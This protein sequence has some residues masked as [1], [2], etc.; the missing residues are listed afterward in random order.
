MDPPTSLWPWVHAMASRCVQLLRCTVQ[1]MPP[2]KTS[3][4]M[5]VQQGKVEALLTMV[6]R[7]VLHSMQKSSVLVAASL[8]LGLMDQSGP[9]DG[10]T[11]SVGLAMACSRCR[12]QVSWDRQ[13]QA[14]V[15]PAE[16]LQMCQVQYSCRRPLPHGSHCKRWKTFHHMGF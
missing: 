6:W 2:F 1:G 16:A 3:K 13:G 4:V 9:R 5:S 11:V 10:I 8:L 7:R 14:V 12:T 15:D